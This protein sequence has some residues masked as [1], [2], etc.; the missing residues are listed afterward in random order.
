MKGLDQVAYEAYLVQSGGLNYQGKPCPTWEELPQ[1]IRDCWQA[2]TAAVLR[3]A[4][5]R[6]LTWLVTV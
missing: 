4:T 6:A 5:E 1:A 2:S 3:D